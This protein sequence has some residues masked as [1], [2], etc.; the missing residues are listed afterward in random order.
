MI[1]YLNQLPDEIRREKLTF[2]AC[3]LTAVKFDN[4]TVQ[5]DISGVLENGYFMF[6]GAADLVRSYM[7]NRHLTVVCLTLYYRQKSGTSYV[8]NNRVLDV[9]LYTPENFLKHY[10]LSADVMLSNKF[11][12]EKKHA[13]IFTGGMFHLYYYNTANDVTYTLAYTKRTGEVET[14]QYE[15]ARSGVNAIFIPYR[16][17]CSMVS[18]NM[19]SRRFVI[20]F[21]DAPAAIQ[22][23][24]RNMFNVLEYISIPGTLTSS[25]STEFET[26]TQN[27]RSIHYDIEHRT[28]FTLKTAALP[29]AMYD[30]LLQVCRARSV[31]TP[32]AYTSGGATFSTMQEITITKYQFDRSTAPDTPVTLEMEYEYADSGLGDIH[33]IE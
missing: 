11:L 3:T 17:D 24:F 1:Y 26:A 28:A 14:T 29:L 15:A 10:A 20:Y 32:L 19:D 5:T 30:S 4:T 22:F 31:L 16:P 9:V 18:I 7:E 23:A 8:E 12:T 21:I 33:V 6:Y 27:H 25:P 13:V 2:D